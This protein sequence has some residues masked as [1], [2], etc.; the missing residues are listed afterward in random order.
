MVQNAQ[1][2]LDEARQM[3]AEARAD[4]ARAESQR[5]SLASRRDDAGRRLER[6]REDSGQTN[7]R[8]KEL[9]RELRAAS[10]KL[11]A[12]KQ[13]RL[14]L[15]AQTESFA[16][17]QV[18][19]AD[20]AQTCEAEVETLRTELQRRKSRLV[21][22][23]EI[24]EKYEGFARGTR[25]VMQK[26]GDL[27]A[28]G[29]AIR[30]LVADVVNAPEQLEAAVEA[31]LGDRLGGILVNSHAA[32]L[33]AVRFLKEA[34]AGRSTFIPCSSGSGGRGLDAGGDVEGIEFEDRSAIASAA[35]DTGGEGVLGRMVDLVRFDTG[36]DQ[37]GKNLLGECV[38][39]DNLERAM[40]LHA[41]GAGARLITLEGDIVDERGAVTGGSREAQGASVLAQKREIRDL[42]E[43]VASL[44]SELTAASTRFVSTKTELG[45]VS[46][47]LEALRQD[48]HQGDVAIMGHEKDVSRLSAELGRL[49]ERQTQLGTEQLELEER[50]ARIASDQAAMHELHESALERSERAERDQLGLIEGVTEGRVRLEE[51]AADLTEAR[52]RAAQLGEKRAAVASAAAG[53]E[54]T[55][56][57]LAERI[58]RLEATIAESAERAEALRA[59]SAALEAEL[60]AMRHEQRG[61]SEALE[62]GRT[63]YET[64]SAGLQI[65]EVSVRELRARAESLSGNGPAARARAGQSR[66]WPARAPRGYWRSLPA[67]AASSPR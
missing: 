1:S 31:A 45:R 51:L 23:V 22:L 28:G 2:R 42:Q 38:V 39:V 19:L 35:A 46:K 67:R 8:V 41:R 65:A 55:D 37:V 16:S 11:A 29:H 61:H 47:T 17:R 48:S 32:G 58:A 53:L 60:V 52:I 18:E 63:A 21:S 33:E 4:L 3:L 5:E 14:D 10:G 64:R 20:A 30:G 49:R 15:G 24:H 12:L 27:G 9:E 26:R 34:G 57:E 40:Q 36:F 44:Q 6:V 43:I 54:G 13:T 7:A 66:Q 62:A 25:A 50:L 59:E 56:R